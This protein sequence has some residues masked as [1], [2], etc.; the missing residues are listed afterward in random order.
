MSILIFKQGEKSAISEDIA[1]MP[2]PEGCKVIETIDQVSFLKAY[3]Q[4][5]S[6]ETLVVFFAEDSEDMDFLEKTYKTFVDIKLLIHLS[7]N[8]NSLYERA[9]QLYPRLISTQNGDE[10]MLLLKAIEVIAKKISQK[11][12]ILTTH[13]TN[14]S[15][16][17]N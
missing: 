2:L 17:K 15:S 10:Y 16:V 8:I 13:K 9:L 5:F 14:K 1:A 4:C 7:D 12:K 6:G 3:S 11:N